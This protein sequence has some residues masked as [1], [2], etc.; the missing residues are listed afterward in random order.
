M[1]GASS[2]PQFSFR[3]EDLLAQLFGLPRSARARESEAD[4]ETPSAKRRRPSN[5]AERIDCWIAKQT[6]TYVD[7]ASVKQAG[8]KELRRLADAAKIDVKGRGLVELEEIRTAVL[9][10]QEEQ[11]LMCL[12]PF[13]KGDVVV[14]AMWPHRRSRKMR[15]GRGLLG[16]RAGRR[17]HAI[18]QPMPYGHVLGAI[19]EAHEPYTRDLFGSWQPTA[20][21]KV[22]G[23]GR[24]TNQ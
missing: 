1:P 12:D 19:G 18:L 10:R 24:A 11:C 15:Q 23:N 8:A 4:E 14:P 2:L 5:D 21:G 16:L 20:K 17:P 22:R 13:K 7:G 3:E 9:N 6:E